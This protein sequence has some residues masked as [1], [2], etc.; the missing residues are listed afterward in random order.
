M[1]TECNA[2]LYL[3]ELGSSLSS[4]KKKKKKPLKKMVEAAHIYLLKIAWL[5]KKIKREIGVSKM[6]VYLK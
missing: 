6:C 5:K 3:G 1:A 2:T 4:L